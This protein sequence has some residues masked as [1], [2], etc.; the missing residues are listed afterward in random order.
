MDAYPEDYVA[1]N[2]PLILLSGLEAEP[3]NDESNVSV[4][5][6]PLL[7]EKGVK[8]DSDFPPLLGSSAAELRNILLRKDASEVIGSPPNATKPK[9][10]RSSG[11]GFKIKSVGRV[12]G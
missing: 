2:R 1:H 3:S 5:Y 4:D 9:K 6:Y 11:A 12:C 8:I 7:Q 10:T